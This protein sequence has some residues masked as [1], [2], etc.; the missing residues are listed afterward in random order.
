MRK[1]IVTVVLASVL[2]AA[3]TALHAED[4]QGSPGSMMGRG[5]MG[6]GRSMMGRTSR[7]MDH[8]GSMM[9]SRGDGGNRPNDQW[10]RPAPST[11]DD[12]G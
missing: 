10:R 1:L 6:Q 9:Q 3:V 4:Q 12:N 5:T 11:P 8:C 2:V 7:M